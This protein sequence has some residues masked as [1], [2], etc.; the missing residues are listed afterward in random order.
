[1]TKKPFRRRDSTTG[2]I[3]QEREK[4][5]VQTFEAVSMIL[6]QE[7]PT[8]SRPADLEQRKSASII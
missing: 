6:L 5:D 1:M 7:Q 3:W 8:S 2:S 4:D